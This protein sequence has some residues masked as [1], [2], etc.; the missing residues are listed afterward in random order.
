MIHFRT[1]INISSLRTRQMTMW[2]FSLQLPV[3]KGLK[4]CDVKNTYF[5]KHFFVISLTNSIQLI[6]LCSWST[7][8]SVTR[9]NFLKYFQR[10]LQNYQKL[11][12]IN[13]SV[14]SVAKRLMQ[15]ILKQKEYLF[16]LNDIMVFYI[17]FH[18]LR[19]KLND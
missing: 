9:K 3:Y 2:Y 16:H 7:Q 14:L 19:R 8:L 10:I 11:S 6:V 1:D 4:I 18:F 13:N 17:G 5:M 15:T 12:K